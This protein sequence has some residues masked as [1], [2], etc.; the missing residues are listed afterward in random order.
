MSDTVKTDDSQTDGYIRIK[1][2]NDTSDVSASI[3]RINLILSGVAPAAKKAGAETQNAFGGAKAQVT[4]LSDAASATTA[5]LREMANTDL[6]NLNRSLGTTAPAVTQ[7]SNAATTTTAELREMALTDLK[8]LNASLDGTVAP[9]KQAETAAEKAAK[10]VDKTEQELKQVSNAAKGAGSAGKQAGI[11]MEQ[12]FDKA[13]NQAQHLMTLMKSVMM[14]YTGKKLVDYFIGSNADMEQY[15]T[16]F[17]T[18]LGSAEKAKDLMSDLQEMANVTPFETTQLTSATQTLLAFG[19]KVENLQDDLSMLGDISLGNA[20]K[21]SS[22]ALVFGQIQSAGRLTG[23]DLLQ[24]VNVGFNPL[25]IIAEQTGQSMDNLRTKMENGEISFDMVRQAMQS[26]TAEG[27]LFYQAMEKQSQTLSGMFSTLK[28]EFAQFGRDSGEEAFGDLNEYVG[29]LLAQLEQAKSDGTL[30]AIAEDVGNAVSAVVQTLIN[31][32]KFIVEHRKALTVLA[33]VYV[34]WKASM[35]M[36]SVITNVYDRPRALFYCDPPY[37]KA[38]KYYNI[39]FDVA[40]HE[41]LKQCLNGIKGLFLLS[42]NDCDFVR[43]LYKDFKIEEV[44]RANNLT[45]GDYKELIISNF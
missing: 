40:D 43:E 16:S 25:Q 27:G 8:S 35:V 45:T 37:Y 39:P 30:A 10:S 29:E 38:E 36:G 23:Q 7:V 4:A 32:T 28:D 31:A 13:S 33:S 41:R 11:D 34:G 14:G 3:E 9:L 12:S 26:A 24:L 6:K 17:E 21:L 22:L 1:T 19:E 15:I 44:S 2:T 18:M 20:D 5:D 42:Y